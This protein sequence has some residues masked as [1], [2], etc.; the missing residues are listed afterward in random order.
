[1][2][3]SFI[4]PCYNCENYI[5]KNIL[6][7]YKKL[8]ISKIKFEI[9][10]IDDFSSDKTYLRLNELKN[11]L[12][13]LEVLKNSK[14]VGKSFSLIRGIKICRYNYVILIDCD[15]PYFKSL[16][17]IIKYLKKNDMVIINRRM[18]GSRQEK[19]ELNFYQ[20]TRSYLGILINNFLRSWFKMSIRDTQAGLKGFIKPKNFSRIKF[21]SKRFF[22]DLELIL[23]FIFAKK[24]I[25]SLKTTYHVAIDSNISF[26]NLKKNFET[27]FELIKICIYYK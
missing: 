12:P 16:P 14:N 4:I 7:L 26:F 25:L 15:L 11:K 3:I 22:F 24:K 10:L 19:N 2:N 18:L 27:L 5:K 1:M 23:L 8:K 17:N 9:I 6:R 21:V 20:L 13:K